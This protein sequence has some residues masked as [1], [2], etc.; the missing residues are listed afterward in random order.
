MNN[1]PL[2]VNHTNTVG[3]A[4][5]YHILSLKKGPVKNFMQVVSCMKEF[6]NNILERLHTKK[7]AESLAN[8][9]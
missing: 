7:C 2:K 6:S 5:I 1:F 4:N 9:K 3:I 8:D